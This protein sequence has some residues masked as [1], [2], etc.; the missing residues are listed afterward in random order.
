MGLTAATGMNQT[1]RVVVLV[2]LFFS[3][4]TN[5]FPT[6]V[7]APTMNNGPRK[8][9]GSQTQYIQMYACIY[10]CSLVDHLMDKGGCFRGG[11]PTRER[12]SELGKPAYLGGQ[13][14]LCNG[15]SG[16][17]PAS[18]EAIPLPD[19]NTCDQYIEH[20]DG[21][22]YDA[23]VQGWHTAVNNVYNSEHRRLFSGAVSA[24]VS[25]AEKYVPYIGHVFC[26]ALEGETAAK[27][28]WTK[29]VAPALG[30]AKMVAKA[31]G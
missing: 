3:V 13:G 5:A 20:A 28:T 16:E 14:L 26:G 25:F 6:N 31:L 19:E 21:M 2:L 11:C 18:R 12:A 1:K 29:C 9:Q 8:L 30:A 27:S 4:A 22:S 17:V 15:I 10:Q 24:F 7:P 23:R